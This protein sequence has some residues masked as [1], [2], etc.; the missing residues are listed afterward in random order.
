MLWG[1]PLQGVGL[2]LRRGPLDF[3][4]MGKPA[5][6]DVVGMVGHDG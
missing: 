2:L 6:V 5:T 3:A 4:W 1:C